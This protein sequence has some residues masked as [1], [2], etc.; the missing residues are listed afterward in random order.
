MLELT[1]WHDIVTLVEDEARALLEKLH[2]RKPPVDAFVLAKALDLTVHIDTNLSTRGYSRKRWGIETV[3]VGSKNPAKSERKHFTIAHEI[4]E[5]LLAG[6]VK[7]SLLEDASNHMAVSLLLPRDRFHKDADALEFDL[8]ALKKRYSTVSH[9]V[10]AYRMLDFKSLI[11]TIFDNSKLYRRK[12]SYPNRL[13]RIKHISPLEMECMEAVSDRAEQ[14]LLKDDEK[15]VTG[16]PIF[17]DNWKRV[18]LKTELKD[19]ISD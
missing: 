13:R 5:M 15:S 7:Q 17:R 2:I 11:I 18:I 8:L 1:E 14:V 12:S 10:I 19:V 9:E 3:T 6:K 4:G 16:W